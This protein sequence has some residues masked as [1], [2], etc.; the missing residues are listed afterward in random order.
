MGH[1][2]DVLITRDQGSVLVGDPVVADP[3][4]VTDNGV[5]VRDH[6]ATEFSISLAKPPRPKKTVTFRRLSSINVEAC[7]HLMLRST[8]S[9]QPTTTT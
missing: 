6:Y 4:L 8:N 7:V 5:R 2:L 3:G 1:T 9:C